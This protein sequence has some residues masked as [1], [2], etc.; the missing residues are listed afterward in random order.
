MHHRDT[1][2]ALLASAAAALSVSSI[3]SDVSAFVHI[4]AQSSPRAG[5]T[6]LNLENHIADM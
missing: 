3:I 6:R 1:F 5:T 2:T 4:A